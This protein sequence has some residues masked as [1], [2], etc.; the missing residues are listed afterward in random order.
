MTEFKPG[1]DHRLLR[2]G[3]WIETGEWMEV[4]SPYDGSL[5]GRVAWD[6][7]AAVKDAIEAAH[8]AMSDSPL[9]PHERAEILD[10]AARIMGDR[11]ESLAHTISAEAGK[12]IALARLEVD[13]ART[14]MA[15]SSK[16]AR[17]LVGEMI[18][19]DGVAA[20]A[21][22]SAMTIR[23]PVGVVAAITPF[24]F[25]LNLSVHKLAPAI[26]AGCGIVHKPADKTPISAVALASCLEDA[27]LPAGWLNL[28]LAEPVSTSEALLEAPEVGLITFT[29]SAAVGW[30]IARAAERTKVSLE[31][32]N[33]TPVIVS[34]SADLDRAAKVATASA[35]G[36]AGQACVSA[37]RVLVDREVH[38][39]LVARMREITLDVRAG[40]P[41]DPETVAG[42]VINA[43]ARDRIVATIDAAVS[44][45]ATLEAG[46]KVLDGN[47]IAPTLIS[48]VPADAE[49]SCRELFGPVLTVTAT[50]SFDQ[51]LEIANSTEYGLQAAVFTESL[52]ETMAAARRLDFG[53]VIINDAPSWRVDP[54]PYG[55]IKASGNTKE[56][57]AWAAREMT[58]EKLLVVT[59]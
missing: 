40:D 20:G 15:E 22:H 27:G 30:S 18:P 8:R 5:V 37:Q 19:V 39:D 23:V 50:D 10:R 46:G 11:A 56:G 55:G 59:G 24:N 21:G 3:E 4:R 48:G 25:P 42:P 57:P 44:A 7:P 16:V 58:E 17:E 41:A 12:P 51:A 53:G 2:A 32:G 13:R 52:P 35:F 9:A 6:G 47:V 43:D 49:I 45:G 14:T 54:M 1:K 31:L 36:F 29:G 34:A 26:A 38:D 28:V 33:S